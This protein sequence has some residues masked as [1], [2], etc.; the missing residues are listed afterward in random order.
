MTFGRYCQLLCRCGAAVLWHVHQ[1]WGVI[2][3]VLSVGLQC[4]C[5]AAV[6][7]LLC[8]VRQACAVSCRQ[9]GA[10]D[11][12]DEGRWFSRSCRCVDV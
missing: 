11:A 2:V 4:C 8:F 1:A 10:A 3:S 6:D 9:R 7:V 5:F 12:V